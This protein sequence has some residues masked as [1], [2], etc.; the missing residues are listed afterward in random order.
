MIHKI[1]CDEN[2]Y[3]LIHNLGAVLTFNCDLGHDQT[4]D[5]IQTN[6]PTRTSNLVTEKIVMEIE[7]PRQS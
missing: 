2:S 1:N 5:G 3:R 4:P 6:R 7:S